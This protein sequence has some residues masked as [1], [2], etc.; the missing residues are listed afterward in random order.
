VN[1]VELNKVSKEIFG[2]TSR[3]YR[4]LAEEGHVPSTV[5]GKIGL[6]ESVKALLVYYREKAEKTDSSIES[7]KVLKLGVE[8]KLKELQLAIRSGDLILKADI[9]RMISEREK[10]VK[11]GLSS[12]HLALVRKLVGKDSREMGRIIKGE[13]SAFLHKMSRMGVE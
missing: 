1:E 6:L 13:V 7:E 3:H 2:I 8:R 12:L 4:R 11:R 10:A 5:R 9:A